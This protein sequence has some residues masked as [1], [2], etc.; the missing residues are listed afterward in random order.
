M[1][2]VVGGEQSEREAE[3]LFA[4]RKFC[5]VVVMDECLVNTVDEITN[6]TLNS[7]TFFIR[8]TL[9]LLRFFSPKLESPCTT[10]Q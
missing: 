5:L 7:L 2:K 4:V 3:N 8:T 1:Q 9:Y 6:H 10:I